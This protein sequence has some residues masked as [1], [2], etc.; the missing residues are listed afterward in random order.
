MLHRPAR[1]ALLLA[2]ALLAAGAR[3]AS[4]NARLVSVTPLDGG[5]VS[6]P[7]GGPSAVQQW[8]VQPGS[9][10]RITISDVVECAEGGTSPTLNM[11][12][13]SGSAGNVDVVATR[14]AVGTYQFDFTV[15]SN[16]RCTMPINY[17]T[18]PGQSETG[19]RVYRSDGIDKQAHLRMVAFGSGCASFT[20]SPGSECLV[21]PTRVSTWSKVKAIYR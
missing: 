20:G 2:I 12:L 1:R 8:N 5:C 7:D 17:G 13:N 3:M 14:V 16:A 4:A 10:Y 9:T 19:F 18:L 21:T 15:P 11:R 6:G